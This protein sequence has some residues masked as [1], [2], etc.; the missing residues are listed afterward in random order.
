MFNSFNLKGIE[1]FTPSTQ[2]EQEECKHEWETLKREKIWSP[3]QFDGKIIPLEKFYGI[4]KKC[5][6]VRTE[7]RQDFERFARCP[8]HEK[9]VKN[10]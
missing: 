3:M 6:A 8:A 4:C 10:E 9:E 5:G 2:K 7:Y 1:I